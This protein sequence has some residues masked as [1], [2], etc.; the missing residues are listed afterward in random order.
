MCIRDSLVAVRSRRDGDLG[1][2]TLEDFLV[3][4]QQEIDERVHD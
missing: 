4:I 2:M 1:T 3:R